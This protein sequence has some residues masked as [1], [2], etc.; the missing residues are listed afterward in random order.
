MAVILCPSS[1]FP[2]LFSFSLPLFSHSLSLSLSLSLARA[3]VLLCSLFLS[4][5]AGDEGLGMAKLLVQY[6]V[7]GRQGG[8]GEGRH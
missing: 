8:G 1:T 7:A 3:R 4:G 2:L 6:I 5:N